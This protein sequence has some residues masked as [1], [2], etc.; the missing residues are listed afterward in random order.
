V[1]GDLAVQE[2]VVGAYLEAARFARRKIEIYI[3]GLTVG[4]A[5]RGVQVVEP[6]RDLSIVTSDSDAQSERR[7]HGA[8]SCRTGVPRFSHVS[9]RRGACAT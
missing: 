4:P 8:A 9:A 7:I 3:G 5:A 6:A 1:T 2:L